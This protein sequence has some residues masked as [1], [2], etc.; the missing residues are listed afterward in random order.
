MSVATNNTFAKLVDAETKKCLIGLLVAFIK[1]AEK[2]FDEEDKSCEEYKIA[3]TEGLTISAKRHYEPLTENVEYHFKN[4]ILTNKKEV[5]HIDEN[6]FFVP[7]TNV[8]PA[9]FSQ[10]L[11]NEVIASEALKDERLSF[12]KFKNQWGLQVEITDYESEEEALGL[13]R[14]VFIKIN[15]ASSHKIHALKEMIISF[16]HQYIFDEDFIKGVVKSNFEINQM[17]A[18]KHS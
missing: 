9:Y 5:E 1:Q 7:M 12:V 6:K 2:D 14:D 4:M 10:A 11:W 13:M 18:I 3:L 16:S 15:K 17:F 8:Q